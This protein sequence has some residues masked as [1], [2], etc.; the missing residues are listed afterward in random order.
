MSAARR[1]RGACARPTV[2]RPRAS[3]RALVAWQNDQA[4]GDI[5]GWTTGGQVNEVS[6]LV[7]TDYSIPLQDAFPI[8]ARDHKDR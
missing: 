7:V 2:E 3:A 8:I 4:A 5:A 6:C 1:T